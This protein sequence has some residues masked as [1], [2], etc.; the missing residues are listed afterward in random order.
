MAAPS[1]FLGTLL[2]ELKIIEPAALIFFG[3]ANKD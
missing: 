1:S 2:T 3:G